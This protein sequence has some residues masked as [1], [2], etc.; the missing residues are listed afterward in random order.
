MFFRSDDKIRQEHK[1]YRRLIWTTK[2][3]PDS[4]SQEQVHV[5]FTVDGV[6]IRMCQYGKPHK[7]WTASNVQI[8]RMR[9]NERESVS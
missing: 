1:M 7:R 4:T 3:I 9:E 5:T 6:V 2:G 8:E